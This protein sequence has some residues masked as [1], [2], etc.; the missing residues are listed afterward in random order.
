M[1]LTLI[2]GALLATCGGA[3]AAQPTIESELIAVSDGEQALRQSLIVDLPLSETWAMFTSE[4]GVS[5]WMAPVAQVDLR[6]GG[7]IRTNYDACAAIGDAG[8]ITL[9]IVNILPERF[10][11]LHT[12]LSGNQSSWMNDAI[13]ARGPDMT[14][15]I[16]F[17]PVGE[18]RTRITSWGLGYGTGEDWEQVTRFFIA[19]N[20]WRFGQLLKA[21]AGEELYAECSVAD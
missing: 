10:L 18:D 9:E 11:L 19:G 5:S 6:S 4:A 2:A 1:R 7:A 12:D 14:N 20:E 16:E 8:T 21:V 15:L 13:R 17:E 3:A